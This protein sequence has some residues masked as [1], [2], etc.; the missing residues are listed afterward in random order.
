MQAKTY[1][2]EI[3]L[4]ILAAG[5]AI[6]HTQGSRLGS[7]AVIFLGASLTLYYLLRGLLYGR[8]WSKEKVFTVSGMVTFV[9]LSFAAMFALS[10]F[11]GAPMAQKRLPILLYTLPLPLLGIGYLMRKYERPDW[12]PFIPRLL[13]LLGIILGLSI[14]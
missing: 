1:K 9:Y 10:L 7:Q 13:I 3:G 8:A 4:A 6:A 2:F 14:S 5:A 12:L 11:F